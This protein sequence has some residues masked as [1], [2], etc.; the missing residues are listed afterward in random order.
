MKALAAAALLGGT[1]VEAQRALDL[2]GLDLLRPGPGTR[3]PTPRRKDDARSRGLAA[4]G[5]GLAERDRLLRQA[6]QRVVLAEMPMT[7]LPEPK[8]AVNAVGIFATP[9]STLKPAFS[10]VSASRAAERFS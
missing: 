4:A 10:R 5:P 7:G 3:Q 1:A 2:A 9:R 8:V 6:G